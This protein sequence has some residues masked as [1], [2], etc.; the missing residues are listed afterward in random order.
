MSDNTVSAII[1]HV[2]ILIIIYIMCFTF[3]VASTVLVLY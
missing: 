3:A 1:I 2:R